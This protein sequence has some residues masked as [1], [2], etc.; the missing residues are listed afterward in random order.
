MA[1]SRS[2]SAFCHGHHMV[3][4]WYHGAHRR[5]TRS[6]I[7]KYLSN[8]LPPQVADVS[9]RF[10]QIVAQWHLTPHKLI[11][12]FFSSESYLIKLEEIQL[13]RSYLWCPRTCLKIQW[14]FVSFLDFTD[15]LHLLADAFNKYEVRQNNALGKFMLIRTY[16]LSLFSQPFLLCVFLHILCLTRWRRRP[17]SSTWLASRPTSTSMRSTEDLPRSFTRCKKT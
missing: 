9:A 12:F 8:H 13:P 16:F 4:L 17:A 6:V 7:I 10:H 3:W 2:T 5:P 1:I 11:Q 15:Q 14:Y